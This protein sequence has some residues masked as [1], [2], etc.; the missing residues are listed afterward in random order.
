MRPVSGQ[1]ASPEALHPGN[2]SGRKRKAT[3]PLSRTPGR[4]APVPAPQPQDDND[5]E[6]EDEDEDGSAIEGSEQEDDSQ[7]EMEEDEEGDGEG[8]QQVDPAIAKQTALRL[9]L[10]AGIDKHR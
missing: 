2:Q 6:D 1:S 7:G 10:S 9:M 4:A 5:N 8:E 3:H